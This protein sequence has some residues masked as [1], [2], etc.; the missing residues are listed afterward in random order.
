MT[1]DEAAARRSN[2]RTLIAI[3]SVMLLF[4]GPLL[5]ALTRYLISQI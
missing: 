3:G 2:R 5:Y 1:D 4:A